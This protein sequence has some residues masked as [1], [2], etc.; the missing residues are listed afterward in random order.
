[1][2]KSFSSVRTE[3]ATEATG[4]LGKDK[5]PPTS[6]AYVLLHRCVIDRFTG[7]IG[8]ET[9]EVYGLYSGRSPLFGMAVFSIA[10][11]EQGYND[12][13]VLFKYQVWASIL[14]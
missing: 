3:L 5:N 8:E 12:E 1:M 13:S 7:C 6:V 10:T 9:F 11:R 2:T 14:A 4:R